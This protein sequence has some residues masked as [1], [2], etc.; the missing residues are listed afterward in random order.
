VGLR[1]QLGDV[2]PWA[3]CDHSVCVVCASPHSANARVSTTADEQ[4]ACHLL[5][6]AANRSASA[7]TRAWCPTALAGCRQY[8]E[9]HLCPRELRRR[10]LSNAA[11]KWHAPRCCAI[12][13]CASRS[14][15]F[16]TR[17]DRNSYPGP[18]HDVRSS[19][20]EPASL[21]VWLIAP[22]V[23]GSSVSE[24]CTGTTKPDHACPPRAGPGL[25]I[26]RAHDAICACRTECRPRPEVPLGSRSGA[27]TARQSRNRADR[28]SSRTCPRIVDSLVK[29]S[30]ATLGVPTDRT[31]P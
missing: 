9:I 12:P 5:G 15:S 22:S 19:Q 3:I 20:S 4:T 8:V 31:E 21:W 16:F 2:L 25:F 27:K 17:L 18:P 13:H 28:Q 26:R 30:R 23:S 1:W 10:L 24:A 11:P 14:H 7:V 6:T 29:S